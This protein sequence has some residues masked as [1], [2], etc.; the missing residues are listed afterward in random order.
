MFTP[1]NSTDNS[2][3]HQYKT[4]TAVI[5]KSATRQVRCKLNDIFSVRGMGHIQ[6][7]GSAMHD[8]WN[9]LSSEIKS[10]FDMLKADSQT[11]FL[12]QII[13][14]K[15]L[16]TCAWI[17]VCISVW[18]FEY[19]KPSILPHAIGRIH[20]AR[21][22]NFSSLWYV[23]NFRPTIPSLSQQDTSVKTYDRRE[24]IFLDKQTQGEAS[25]VWNS[26]FSSAII[27]ASF[28]CKL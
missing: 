27:R 21:L 10:E 19:K 2:S 22:L 7:F 5:I 28:V 15:I 20:D 3:L 1:H 14:R 17:S 6:N 4:L 24:W 18:S 13:S 12:M 11:N 25:H 9:M 8:A 26:G 16:W 23:N